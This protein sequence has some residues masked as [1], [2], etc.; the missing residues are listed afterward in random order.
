MI[1]NIIRS[2]KK[3]V[4]ARHTA[5]R[6][7]YWNHGSREDHEN[8]EKIKEKLCAWIPITVE[9]KSRCIKSQRK[10]RKFI[11][12]FKFS[13]FLMEFKWNLYCKSG[14]DPNDV[15]LGTSSPR[16]IEKIIRRK[17]ASVF[18]RRP[19]WTEST[20]RLDCTDST[21]FRTFSRL[22][23]NRKPLSHD[24]SVKFTLRSN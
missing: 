22:I 8:V 14:L 10:Q 12:L 4:F 17:V 6:G 23:P 24:R 2:P 15:I 16:G 9:G 11:Y 1:M 3:E 7:V 19:N 20:E 21:S 18:P 5:S 13:L